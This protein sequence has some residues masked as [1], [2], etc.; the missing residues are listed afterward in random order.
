M[1]ITGL[2][3]SALFKLLKIQRFVFQLLLDKTAAF[4]QGQVLTQHL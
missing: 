1:L 2:L 4:V 3:E